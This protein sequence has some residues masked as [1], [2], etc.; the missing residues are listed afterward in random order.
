MVPT[1]ADTIVHADAVLLQPPT[2]P[3]ARPADPAPAATGGPVRVLA[4]VALTA[5]L[6][7][8][9]A[10]VALPFL[11]AI[12]WAV[13]LAI[14]AWPLHR[15]IVRRIDNRTL[16]AGLTTAAVVVVILVPGVWVGYQL[17]SQVGTA[18]DQLG[19]NGGASG[20]RDRLAEVPA[21]APAVA[22][23]ERLNVNVEA[24]ART[25]IA[26]YTRDAA[27]LAQGSVAAVLQFLVV[28]FLL[29][30]VFRDRGEFL[31]GARDVLPLSG[32]EADQVFR[33]VADSVHANLYATV[34]TSAIDAVTGGLVFW[35]VGLP[36][37]V[38]WAAV[39]FVLAL[40][41]VVGA[42]M[43]WLPAVGFLALSG[44][45][46]GAAAVLGWGLTVF[47]LVDNLLYVRLAG[48]R[49]RM[50][51]AYAL[52]AFL[53]GLAVFGVSGIVLGPAAFAVTMAILKV[54]RRR[55][56]GVAPGDLAIP[57]GA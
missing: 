40:L 45:W 8:L 29:F 5:M 1:A 54:W 19:G 44:N 31:A 52:V 53:G 34:V 24:E 16:A 12:T 41:P 39:M 37:P 14:I 7:A 6:L 50:H 57:G 55:L 2:P 32:A 43:V 46:L 3:A 23:L 21:L 30:F 15:W 25:I 51:Q 48:P 26:A 11:P 18:A 38:A 22:W 28:L 36:A 9:C 17:A 42:A 20:L 35:A 47:V 33:G 56:T 10:W 13:A 49:M 4:L 27:Q